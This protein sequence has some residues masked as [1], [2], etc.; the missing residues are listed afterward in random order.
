VRRA[1]DAIPDGF[2]FALAVAPQGPAMVVG[3]NRAGQ[4]KYLGG[5]PGERFVDLRLTIKNIDAAILL[6]TFQESTVTAVARDR[7]IVDGDIP[8]ACTVVRILD[9]VEVFLLPR[10]LASLAVRRYPRWPPLRKYGGRLLIYLRTVA[11]F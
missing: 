8:A 9:M 10:L 7:M 6:F 11:G 5:D 2:T 3:K 4:V 1:F